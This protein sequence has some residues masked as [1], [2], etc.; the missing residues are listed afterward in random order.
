MAIRVNNITISI[1]EEK[2]VLL[3]KVAKKLKVKQEDIKDF[4]IIKESLD[5]RK[6]N[7]I[8]YTYCIELTI[9]DEE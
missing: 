8:K 4:K 2:N 6:K 3:N 5:A 7:D 9:K 1:N